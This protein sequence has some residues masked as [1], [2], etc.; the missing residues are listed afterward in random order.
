VRIGAPSAVSA[1]GKGYSVESRE[2]GARNIAA[3]SYGGGGWTYARSQN[4]EK[5]WE[6]LGRV[7][8]R[9]RGIPV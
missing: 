4:P 6:N 7:F 2:E 1:S 8:G 5:V 9:L 3:W